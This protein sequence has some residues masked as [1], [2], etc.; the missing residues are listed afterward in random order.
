[1]HEFVA[2]DIERT[3]ALSIA[4]GISRAEE[5][6]EHLD[7]AAEKYRRAAETLTELPPLPEHIPH[8][9]VST[10]G[11]S[12]TLTP[13]RRR[14][15]KAYMRLRRGAA[16]QM[17]RLHKIELEAVGELGKVIDAVEREKQQ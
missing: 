8:V 16:K 6:R 15:V 4:V 13:E 3:A 7:E 12:V 17:R 5:A 1:M 14:A 2:D 9:T 11:P 10:N